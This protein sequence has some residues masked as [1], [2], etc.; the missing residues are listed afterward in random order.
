MAP[1][2]L[3]VDQIAA[4]LRNDGYVI[5][6]GVL[7]ADE[8]AEIK[9]GL[10]PYLAVEQRGR[11]NFEGYFTERVYSLIGC[12]KVFEA[13]AEHPLILGV[14]DQLLLPSYLLTASQAINIQPG[15]TRQAPHTDDAFYRLP[16][17]RQAISVS[18]MWAIDAFTAENGATEIIHGSHAWADAEL[19]DVLDTIDFRTSP[20]GDRVPQDCW[21][22]PRWEAALKPALMPAGS[23]M[24]FLGTL[25]HRGGANRSKAPRLAISNQYCE[26]W[27]RQQENFMMS[28]PAEQTLAMS[29]RL[30]GMLGYSIYPP[31]MG[32]VRG[33]H[34]KRVLERR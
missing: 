7:S 23:V 19:K 1:S 27:A 13:L 22:S 29:D 17:P 24:I 11:N 30:Q 4:A 31:F 28:I 33:I 9:E 15:E 10:D 14:C 20:L 8:I 16:R 21:V 32:H 12:G 2:D 26:P 34:P 18:T 25:L 3:E 6:E 5:C